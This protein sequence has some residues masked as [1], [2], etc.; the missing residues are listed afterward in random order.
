MKVRKS[1]NYNDRTGSGIKYL[2]LHYTGM[3]TGD[4]ALERLCDQ[5][6]EVSAHYMIRENGEVISLVDEQKRAWH[7]GV[8]K[9]QK[10]ED[11]NDLSIGIEL[12]NVGHA[13]PGYQSEYCAF[14][15]AQMEALVV[16]AKDII[17]RYDIKPWNVLGHSDVAWP[18]K[19]DPGEL[20]DWKL[21]FENGVGLWTD[22]HGF[23]D[24]SETDLEGFLRSLALYG[25]DVS[26]AKDDP[27]KIISAFQRHFR[28]Q[29]IAG[30]LDGETVNILKN[31]LLQK[32][33]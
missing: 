1:P 31:L 9:W 30:E 2:I 33:S 10:D 21:L 28:P 32:I 17:N 22:D 3:A 19:I 13:Y 29:N 11:I 14:P 23:E 12:V 15:R 24:E 4:E 27:G 25:Y 8:S 5:D 18:R 6:A 20:F 7:A 16:L 26:G